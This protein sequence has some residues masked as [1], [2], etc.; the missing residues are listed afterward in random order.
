MVFQHDMLPIYNTR[1]RYCSLWHKYLHWTFAII[2]GLSFAHI[3]NRLIVVNIFTCECVSVR[4]REKDGAFCYFTHFWCAI[5]FD[6]LHKP[7]R[8]G[9]ENEWQ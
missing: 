4:V 3:H 5:I 7:K 9:K 6:V 8:I 1:I 2:L